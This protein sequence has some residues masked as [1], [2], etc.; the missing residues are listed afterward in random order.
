MHSLQARGELRLRQDAFVLQPQV[1]LKVSRRRAL[2]TPLQLRDL[3][4]DA[5][6]ILPSHPAPPARSLPCVLVL[7]LDSGGRGGQKFVG[8]LEDPVDRKQLR[9]VQLDILQV[10]AYHH[11][12]LPQVNVGAEGSGGWEDEAFDRNVV[13]PD[14]EDGHGGSGQLLPPL[15]HAS[16]NVYGVQ[17]ASMVKVCPGILHPRHVHAG[18]VQ[19]VLEVANGGEV[20]EASTPALFLRPRMYCLDKVLVASNQQ[21][22]SCRLFLKAAQ[23][24]CVLLVVHRHV[25]D[26]RARV[27][28]DDVEL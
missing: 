12:A 13:P 3:L 14:D 8:W 28:S 6:A 5:P 7:V 26:D 17:G 11:A 18:V 19:A 20:G 10:F 16:H 21:I 15:E 2:G 4:L 25:R 27:T 24:V 9:A 22:P 1:L 23:E